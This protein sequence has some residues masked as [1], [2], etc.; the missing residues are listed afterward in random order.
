MSETY[1]LDDATKYKADVLSNW[2]STRDILSFLLLLAAAYGL[3]LYTDFS[4]YSC[5]LAVI[6]IAKAQ[7]SLMISGH[8]AIHRL[9]FKD[10]R[11][12]DVIGSLIC[13][14]PMGIGFY[15]ARA[16]HIDHHRHTLTERDEER[17]IAKRER[18]LNVV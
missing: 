2:V 14:A 4:R 12:N 17:W 5:A 13:C 3:L 10:R 6:L 9:L 1:V 7:Y 15:R 8:E 18:L 11:I 16:A